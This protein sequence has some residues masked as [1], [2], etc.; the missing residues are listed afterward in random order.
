MDISIKDGSKLISKVQVRLALPATGTLYEILV[1]KKKISFMTSWA[2]INFS[3]ELAG[4]IVGELR[5]HMYSIEPAV[6]Y[7]SKFL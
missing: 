1:T 4:Y 7:I 2:T 5:W 3:I 6:K